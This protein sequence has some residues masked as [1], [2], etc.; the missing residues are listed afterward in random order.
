[1]SDELLQMPALT[2]D[3]IAAVQGTRKQEAQPWETYDESFNE[4]LGASLE[5]AIEEYS[6]VDR[7]ES[8]D[9]QTLET[10]AEQKEMADAAS[11]EYQFV[12]PDEYEDRG[13]RIGRIIH[14]SHFIEILQQN[15]GLTC[16]YR[17]HPEPRKI[18]LVVDRTHGITD[19]ETACWVQEGFMPEFSMMQFDDHGVPISE[20]FRGWR[21]CLLQLILK[22]MLTEP[23]ATA[24][25]GEATGPAAAKYNAY[26]YGFRNTME[27]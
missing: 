6:K 10:L 23:I 25:F 26:L 11:R 27:E 18:T 15:C 24:V 8:K 3:E 20:E 1:M 5:A 7:V 21:T 13:A 14:S 16:W 12:T 17:N 19:P 9:S 4:R 22:K 2:A